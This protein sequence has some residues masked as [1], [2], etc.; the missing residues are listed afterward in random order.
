MTQEKITE[1]LEEIAEE[2]Y[3]RFS[4]SLI[5]NVDNIIG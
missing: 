3:R 2:N 5:P 4:S 1:L